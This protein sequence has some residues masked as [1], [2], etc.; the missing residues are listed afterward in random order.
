MEEHETQTSR[1]SNKLIDNLSKSL[2]KKLQTSSSPEVLN[3]L[4]KNT[5]SL[6][7]AWELLNKRQEVGLVPPLPSFGRE[8]SSLS[9]VSFGST[10]NHSIKQTL[11]KDEIT[12]KPF[13]V[14]NITNKIISKSEFIHQSKALLNHRNVSTN[15][16]SETHFS[17]L[18]EFSEIL[19]GAISASES[20]KNGKIN[21]TQLLNSLSSKRDKKAF[22]RLFSTSST[23]GSP[24]GGLNQLKTPQNSTFQK[25]EHISPCLLTN[26][27]NYT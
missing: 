2:A 10:T 24:I 18:K 25:P 3:L 22:N 27:S 15:K 12:R 1:V 7:M 23:Q 14:E 17:K 9:E 6:N 8:Q 21:Y 19:I 11:N 26:L 20:T 4:F 16:F 5:N 13:W